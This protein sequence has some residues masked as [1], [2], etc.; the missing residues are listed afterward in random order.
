MSTGQRLS[1]RA[2]TG[3]EVEKCYGVTQHF[4]L[5]FMFPPTPEQLK[6]ARVDKERIDPAKVGVPCNWAVFAS[7]RWY[8]E[9]PDRHRTNTLTQCKYNKHWN[10]CPF[11]AVHTCIPINVELWP[12]KPFN[13]QDYDA[14]GNKIKKNDKRDDD[15]D[16]GTDENQVFCVISH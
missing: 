2:R 5:H 11:I 7:C 8:E 9:L 12:A 15:Y 6:G 13:I 10:A 4:Y 3:V 1:K 16:G 14:D